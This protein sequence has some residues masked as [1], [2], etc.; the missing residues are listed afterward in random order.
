[1]GPLRRALRRADRGLTL[2][3]VLINR[4]CFGNHWLPLG[5]VAG[6]LRVY[7][8]YCGGLQ[9]VLLAFI[10]KFSSAAGTSPIARQDATR[11]VLRLTLASK[12]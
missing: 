8:L 1:M 4:D 2:G 3:R 11:R 9:A 7:S 6:G 10:A 12:G 5:E